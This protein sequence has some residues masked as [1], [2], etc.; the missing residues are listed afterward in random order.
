MNQ[1]EWSKGAVRNCR[2]LAML[3]PFSS[4]HIANQYFVALFLAAACLVEP[5]C[6]L[7]AILIYRSQGQK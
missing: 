6:I 1:V 3:D 4:P 5:A 7:S 2:C